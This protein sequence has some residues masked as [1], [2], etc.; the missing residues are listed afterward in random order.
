VSR[1]PTDYELSRSLLDDGYYDPDYY[2]TV[3]EQL[4]CAYHAKNDDGSRRYNYII[5]EGSSRS[6]KTMS[7][8]QLVYTLATENSGKRISAWRK[9]KH[10]CRETVGKSFS[11]MLQIANYNL[12]HTLS[13]HGTDK[14]YTTPTGCRI[15]F[16]GSDDKDKSHGYEAWLNWFNE[17]HEVSKAVFDQIDMRTEDVTIIDWNPSV[18]C[19]ID[20][21]KGLDEAIT[22]HSTFLDNQFCPPKERHKILSYEPWEPGSYKVVKGQ[23]I[24]KGEPISAENSPPPHPTNVAK[25]TASVFDWMVYGLGLKGRDEF[26]I[27]RNWQV[28]ESMPEHFELK[29]FGYGL[30]FGFSNDPAA[31]IRCGVYDGDIYLDEVV[32]GTG[33]VNAIND[34]YPD[35]RSIEHGLIEDGVKKSDQIIADSSEPKSIREMRRAG[36]SVKGVNKKQDS[37]RAGIKGLQGYNLNITKRS[38]NLK[39][40]FEKYKWKEDPATGLPLPVPV[41]KDNHA[42]DAIRYWYLRHFR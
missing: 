6:S 37:V 8:C 36:W 30:D 29:K 17:A 34:Q 3:F 22:I 16:N 21:I 4:W 39:I 7:I 27:Y 38:V 20:T 32:Y 12:S 13:F 14:S 5:L 26:T 28:V 9:T 33:L 24:Y 25:G 15:E 42:C 40:E 41:D 1:A 10:N 2:T 31:V 35:M 19:F 11:K 18:D 23:I